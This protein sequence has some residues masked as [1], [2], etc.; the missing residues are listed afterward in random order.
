MDKICHGKDLMY[1]KTLKFKRA[2]GCPYC[3]D[4][5]NGFAALGLDW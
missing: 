4:G 3:Y 2:A 5:K 1:E